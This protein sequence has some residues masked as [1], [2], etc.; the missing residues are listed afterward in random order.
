VLLNTDRFHIAP[1][2]EGRALAEV[3]P[4]GADVLAGASRSHPRGAV[5]EPGKEALDRLARLR[6][7]VAA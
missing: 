2:G 1:P 6:R 5:N 4:P 7:R 3:L